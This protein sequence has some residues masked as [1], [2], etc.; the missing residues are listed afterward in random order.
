[1]KAWLKRNLLTFLRRVGWTQSEAR[2]TSDAQRYWRQTS[3]KHAL[4]SHWRN[5]MEPGAWESLGNFHRGLF[6]RFFPERLGPRRMP[7]M[8]EWGCGGG[9]NAIAFSDLVE[10]FIGVDLS[11]ESLEECRRQLA[12]YD[13]RYT[14]QIVTATQPESILGSLNN[15]VDFFLCTF[16]FEL[17]PTEGVA[18]QILKVAHQSLRDGGVAM[19]QVKYAT[20]DPA[21]R[22]RRFAYHLDLANTTTFPIE[23]FWELACQCGFVPRCVHLLPQAPLVHD[24]RYAYFFLDRPGNSHPSLSPSGSR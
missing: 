3:A 20:S 23:Q 2:M 1:M 8:M 15:S 5:A 9:A 6:E 19:I 21:T 4:N 11:P 12:G 13:V 16:V 17:L 10:E 24:E 22:S 18:T 7:R 14:P